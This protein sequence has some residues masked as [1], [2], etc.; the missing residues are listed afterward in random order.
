MA[1]PALTPPGVH[2]DRV[3]VLRDGAPRA[4]GPVVYWMHRSQRTRA[5][6]ALAHARALA[7]ELG[8]PLAVVGAVA[9][10]GPRATARAATFELQGWRDVRDGL[11][12]LGVGFALAAADPADVALAAATDAAVLVVD[13]G[14]LRADVAQRERVAAEAPCPVVQVEGDVVVPVDVASPKAE[15]MARTLR[16]K[17]HRVFEAYLDPV[18]E[19]PASPPWRGAAPDLGRF[20]DVAGALDDVPALVARLDV[21]GTVA[22]VDALYPG[23]ERAAAARLE[24]FV[25]G[26]LRGYADDRNQPHRARV[27]YLGMHLR[28]GQVS[29]VEAL[30]A[31]RA[32][33]PAA[34]D[35]NVAS[36][37]EELLVRRELAI[38]HAVRNPAYD[39]YE[40]LPAWARRT[41]EAHATD[42]R[43]ATY[44]DAT[45]EAAESDDPY[46]NAAMR[47]S[48]ATGYQHNHMRM[49][50]G[51]KVLEWSATPEE[52]YARL[53][54]WND[55]FHLDGVDPNG[56]AG[57]GW[58]FG[59]HDRP[60][61]ERP[62]FGT[63]RSMTQGGLKRKTDP[64]AYVRA[65]AAE[66]AR[67]GHTP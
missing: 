50:W 43:P 4:S 40:G 54:R 49:Y 6:P 48:V 37:V 39:R 1:H 30:R 63:V 45:L 29:P 42:P 31:A 11:A 17:L 25:A 23:G 32:A 47:Q 22:P 5:N 62:V 19:A 35:A 55:R 7:A 2:P 20:A 24:A 16:P 27:S 61:T 21:D 66:V 41:L 28:C 34:G 3:Q 51:K 13:R 15:Y 67:L 8:R 9:P 57:V 65:V 44:D 38:N 60:W 58:V 56:Y 18:A 59:L 14:Y 10:R 33:A 53:V 64:E 36:F 12:S 52:A 46:W 26:A